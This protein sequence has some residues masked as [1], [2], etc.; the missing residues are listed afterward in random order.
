VPADLP[1]LLDRRVAALRQARPDL[2][3]GLALQALL[4]RETLTAVRPPMARFPV[5]PPERVLHKIRDGVPLLHTESIDVDVEYAADL[6]GR[7]LNVVTGHDETRNADQAEPLIAAA[8]DG[9]L[10]PHRL[11]AEAFV[12]HGDHVAQMA[13]A[14]GVEAAFLAALATL[15]IAPVLRA[16]AAQVRPIVARLDAAA[17]GAPTWLQGYCPACGAWPL[18]G[19][20]RGVEMRLALRCSACGLDWGGRRLDCPFCG[21]VDHRLLHTL[22]IEGERRFRAQA[23][24]GCHNYLKVGNAFDPPPGELLALDDLASVNLDVAAIDRGYR[25]PTASGFRLEL[26]VPESEA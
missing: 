23:C 7:L 6:F 1:L 14:A 24:D 26:A 13:Q 4:I 9:R 21:T 12:Q 25:R 22:Q 16:Y 17:P 20:L 18:L 3:A 2:E 10:D 11:F 15:A 5:V 8:T 19:E